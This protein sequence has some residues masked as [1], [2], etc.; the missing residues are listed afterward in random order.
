MNSV[1]CGVALA[2]T[3]FRLYIR[4]TRSRLWWDDF[5]IV[6]SALFTVGLIVVNFLHTANPGKR[7]LRLIYGKANPA[8]T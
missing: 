7:I 1:L 3:A 5:W 6:I 2:V 4:Y 8:A